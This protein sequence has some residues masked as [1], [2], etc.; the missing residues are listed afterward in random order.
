MK[1]LSLFSLGVILLI[2]QSCT[3]IRPGEVGV[4]VKFGKAKQELL[5]PGAHHFAP[6]VFRY[7]VRYE[8]RTINHNK[9]FHFH[10]KEGIYVDADVTI[11]YHIKESA[12]L[13]VHQKY[14]PNYESLLIDDYIETNLRKIGLKYQAQ[15]LIPA[16]SEIEMAL[17]HSMDSVMI[18]RG[19][20]MESV[21]MKDFRLPAGI[22]ATIQER[23]KAEEI[24][25]RTYVENKTARERLDFAI[26]KGIKE[27]ELEISKSRLDLEFALE[28]QKIEAERIIVAAEAEK[29][30]QS[31]ENST[32]TDQLLKL[33]AIELSAEALKSNSKIIITDGKTPIVMGGNG[34]TVPGLGD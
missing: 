3:I 1:I 7:V 32:I 5:Q 24:A 34:I 23:L 21:I 26:E 10:S 8:T 9:E 14:G 25:K 33:R 30:R 18:Q 15:E 17:M 16:R 27:K 20:V 6:K 11:L 28:R 19:I 2:I 29:K 4:D 22:V 12:I 31:L 13:E